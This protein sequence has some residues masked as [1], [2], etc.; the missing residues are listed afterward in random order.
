MTFSGAGGG[1]GRDSGAIDRLGALARLRRI[2]EA[3]GPLDVRL[4]EQC[5][6][7]DQPWAATGRQH[8]VA[9]TTVRRWTILAL[10]RLKTVPR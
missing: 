2:A 8:S 9:D 7:L 1:R 3:L 4:I 5:V 10:R 6:V